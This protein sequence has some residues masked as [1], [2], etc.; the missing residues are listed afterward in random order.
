MAT[1]IAARAK[2]DD[3]V[4]RMSQHLLKALTFCVLRIRS[5]RRPQNQ[6]EQTGKT[7]AKRMCTS[8]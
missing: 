7:E 1:A 5:V 8:A 3:K 6:E 2:D 4:A